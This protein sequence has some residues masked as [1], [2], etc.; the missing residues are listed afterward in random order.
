MFQKYL[1]YCT[2][3]AGSTLIEGSVGED[4]LQKSLKSSFSYFLAAR[5]LKPASASPL[6]PPPTSSSA[7]QLSGGNEETTCQNFFTR[8]S[9]S[10][11]AAQEKQQQQPLNASMCART[12]HLRFHCLKIRVSLCGGVWIPVTFHLL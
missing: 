12:L 9:L 5:E 1:K 6:P 4:M 10:S 2:Q 11:Q 3:Y 8:T 7:A